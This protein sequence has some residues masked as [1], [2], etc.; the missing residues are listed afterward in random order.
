MIAL[1]KEKREELAK[2]AKATLNSLNGIEPENP[3]QY[4][5]YLSEYTQVCMEI[6]LE[7]LTAEPV[8]Y[9]TYKGYLLHAADPKVSEYSDPEPL[10]DAPPVPEINKDDYIG[11]QVSV[12]VSTSDYDADHRYFGKVSALSE[13]NGKIVLVIEEP[14]KNFTVSP[15]PE[16]KLPSDSDFDSWFKSIEAGDD[17]NWQEPAYQS[18]EWYQ[19]LS[20]RQLAQGAFNFYADELKYLNGL[21]E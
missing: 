3:N 1:T 19:Y 18:V 9:M 20:R 6:A 12:D 21:G 10:Y 14:K 4:D 16:I 11:L 7:S 17:G 2:F 5:D 13:S 15:V 8:A